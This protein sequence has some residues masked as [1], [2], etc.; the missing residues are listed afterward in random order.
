MV[1][2]PLGSA[3]HPVGGH[4]APNIHQALGTAGR[5]G[6]ALVSLSGVADD[7]TALVSPASYMGP[8]LR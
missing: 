1:A 7:P 4:Q 6:Q 8:S 5:V 2:T 3:G